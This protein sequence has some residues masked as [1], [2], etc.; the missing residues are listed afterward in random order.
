MYTGTVLFDEVSTPSGATDLLLFRAS[1]RLTD[2][3]VI[4][5]FGGNDGDAS[6]TTDG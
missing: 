1:L 6:P 4:F 3:R 2:G 5:G